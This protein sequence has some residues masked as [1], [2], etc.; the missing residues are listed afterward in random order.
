MFVVEREVFL[1]LQR[2]D[3]EALALTCGRADCAELARALAEAAEAAKAKP[4]RRQKKFPPELRELEVP[5]K[6]IL[7]ACLQ[8]LAIRGVFAWRQNQGAMEQQ[9]PH[10]R[11]G[12]GRKPTRKIRFA[13]VDGI[14]DIIGTYKGRFLAIETKRVGKKP[15]DDQ[16]GFLERID[17]EGGIAIVAYSVDDVKNALDEVD[18]GL[19]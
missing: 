19:R 10:Y 13:H 4:A 5:E 15:T 1:A 9:N 6:A 12:Y 11:P 17:K 16:R 18:K 3:A 14:S 7:S 8:Y 2:G